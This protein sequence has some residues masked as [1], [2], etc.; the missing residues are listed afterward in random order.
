MKIG[1]FLSNTYQSSL[2]ARFVRFVAKAYGSSV[3]FSLNRAGELDGA[4]GN[5]ALI[6]REKDA[7]PF[8]K[9]K[10]LPALYESAEKLLHISCCQLAILL[11][12]FLLSLSV[13]GWIDGS[14]TEGILYLVCELFVLPLF[15]SCRSVSAVI[16]S[17]LIGRFFEFKQ[18]APTQ[19]QSKFMLCLIGVLGIIGG[20]FLPM[21]YAFLLPLAPALL[22]MLTYIKP[23]GFI[24]LIMVC[25]PVFG[26]SVC[27]TLC[28]LLALSQW[29]QR[30]YGTIGK[31]RL[32]YIDLLLAAYIALCLISSLFSFSVSDSLRVSAMWIIM[33]STVFIIIRNVRSR[34]D[35]VMSLSWLMI[36]AVIAG[37]IGLY[38]YLSGQVDTTWTDTTLFQNLDIRIYS[39]FA[40]P[41]V[42]GEFLLLVIP[43]AAG[44]GIYF[45]KWK[46]KIACFGTLALSL[47][48]LALTYSRGCYVGLVV[49]VLVF[50]WMY[51]KKI[52]GILL[53]VGTPVGIMMLPQNMIDRIL[54]MVNLADSSTSYRLK[55]YEGSFELLKTY[56]PS[57]LGIGEAAFNYV[58]PFFGIQG[59]VA[60][61]T[62]SLFLQLMTS[63]GIA[64]LVY[65]AFL[66]FVYHRNIISFEKRLKHTDRR[67]VL[68]I[69]FGSVL[70]GFL[71]QS[72]FDYTWYNYRVYFL[73]WIVV[74]LGFATYKILRGEEKK[75]D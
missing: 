24:C 25:L 19:K 41:N 45:N 75:V 68:L 18:D 63:F 44:L 11:F 17:S 9:G 70:F 22:V 30:F 5:S 35:L 56:W 28:I 12:F 38:Q 58:Y 34:R 57:G 67:K 69:T 23:I 33:F 66:M 16:G 42:F 27:I 65:F 52:L 47:I 36:G 43:L 74:A 50:L 37:V 10:I 14:T 1:Q 31:T 3:I 49:T 29:L 26:T 73:F 20:M 21:P 8:Q 32:D 15:F 40:N 55:I 54:S 13:S 4:I 60:P 53:V 71:V 62:H 61:H 48:A 64:G 59:I 6:G 7:K 2:L 51:N 72:I 39:T 46:Y